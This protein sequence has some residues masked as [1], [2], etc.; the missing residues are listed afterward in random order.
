MRVL[1]FCVHWG[2]WLAFICWPD[3]KC[4]FEYFKTPCSVQSDKG[5]TWRICIHALTL[6]GV[7]LFFD[8][9]EDS[10]ESCSALR[11]HLFELSVNTAVWA[12][13][14]RASSNTCFFCCLFTGLISDLGWYRGLW[15]YFCNAEEWWFTT[16][17]VSWVK[18]S[19]FLVFYVNL[20]FL[21]AV[22]CW[23]SFYLKVLHEEVIEE[24]QAL[25]QV[26]VTA[27]LWDVIVTETGPSLFLSKGHE[28]LNSPAEMFSCPNFLF[29]FTVSSQLPWTEEEMR[30][31][32]QQAVSHQEADCGIWWTQA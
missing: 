5:K 24:Y 29:I 18:P 26:C 13:S 14:E 21:L 1:Q 31:S 10:A 9:W 30:V 7:G 16:K 20:H 22:K 23:F 15:V 6:C 11:L 8:A 12:T 3:C 32:P 27:D 4:I 19:I 25:A 17:K 2:F 28:I